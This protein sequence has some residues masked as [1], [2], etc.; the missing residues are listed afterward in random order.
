[1][2]MWGIAL[3]FLGIAMGYLVI[4]NVVDFI[5]MENNADIPIEEIRCKSIENT[6]RWGS[7]E[8][9]IF[10]LDGHRHQVLQEDWD[11]YDVPQCQ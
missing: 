3:A 8:Y 6:G 4:S 10:D 2:K 5:H 7:A 1:M 9:Y 11:K